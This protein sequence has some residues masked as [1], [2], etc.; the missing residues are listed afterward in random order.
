M[1]NFTSEQIPSLWARQLHTE[2]DDICWKY[3]IKLRPPVF[4]ISQSKKQLG[5]WHPETRTIKISSFL[6]MNHSWAVTLNVLKH[7]IAHQVCYEMFKSNEVAHGEA[8]ST[9]CDLLGLPEEYRSATGDLPED[10]DLI[11]QGRRP[12]S[13]ESRFISKVEKLLALA[14]STN[15]NEA[16]SA[17]Q[18]ANALIEKYN[19][20]LI[21]SGRDAHYTHVI[22]N[23][24]KKRVE[25]YQR[26]ICRILQEFFYV[27]I[28]ASYLYDP[29][30]NETH[31]TIELLGTTENVSI[32]EYCYYFLEKRLDLL[33]LQNKHRYQGKTRTEKNSYYLGVLRG[34][35]DKLQ[36]QKEQNQKNSSLK[37]SN[38][39]RQL[40]MRGSALISQDE[41]LHE[42]VGIRFPRLQKQSH[43]GPKIY[44]STYDEGIET[45]K[46]ITLHKG[47]A[48]NEG[49]RGKLIAQ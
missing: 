34:F 15:A 7:E 2:F 11:A 18:K 16:A 44:K 49:N 19:L 10:I 32:A 47:V 1:K 29:I 40:M 8:F 46:K 28:V 14:E 36:N 24:K 21:N 31:K 38:E 22:I 20:K 45:G 6:I 42:Y 26:Q 30:S 17:M 12:S 48:K 23:K 5:S 37:Q 33:W 27:K 9:A 39:D 13:E 35:Y 43:R 25:S 4:E 41:R 3:K